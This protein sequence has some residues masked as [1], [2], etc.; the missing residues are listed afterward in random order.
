MGWKEEINVP[1]NKSNSEMAI[2][3][4]CLLKFYVLLT[5]IVIKNSI[6]KNMSSLA[7][8]TL[9]KSAKN[10]TFLVN[11]YVTFNEHIIFLNYL[12]YLCVG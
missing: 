9:L 1:A 8:E 11:K 3:N 12:D 2:D 6:T 10:S 5:L 7:L 4:V